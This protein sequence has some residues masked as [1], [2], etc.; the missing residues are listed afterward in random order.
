MEKFTMTVMPA[1]TPGPTT[2]SIN[3]GWVDGWKRPMFFLTGSVAFSGLLCLA[4]ARTTDRDRRRTRAPGE[5]SQADLLMNIRWGQ[6]GKDCNCV[7]VWGGCNTRG[8]PTLNNSRQ[9]STHRWNISW[10]WTSPY[11][12]P[13]SF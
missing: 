12:R 4:E 7:C 6:W 13:S 10:H 9:F 3:K 8:A 5:G 2:P 11:S 1:T